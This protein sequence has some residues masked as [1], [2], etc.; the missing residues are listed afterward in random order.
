MLCHT[1]IQNKMSYIHRLLTAVLHK[2][3]ALQ[4]V[5][6]FASRTP[7]ARPKQPRSKSH[8]LG[9]AQLSPRSSKIR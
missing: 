1:S 9:T 5:K 3:R 7:A 4:E 8:P 6:A 2:I